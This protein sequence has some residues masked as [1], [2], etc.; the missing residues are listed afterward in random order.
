MMHRNPMFS[1]KK[2]ILIALIFVWSGLALGKLSPLSEAKIEEISNC[3][4]EGTVY[5]SKPVK[6]AGK[7]T[8][9]VTLIA[10]GIK[11]SK[12]IKSESYYC[13]QS[14]SEIDV[15]VPAGPTQGQDA[16]KCFVPETSKEKLV[17]RIDFSNQVAIP[18]DCYRWV[19]DKGL[20]PDKN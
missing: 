12:S 14:K 17:F 10:V 5:S 11:I 6:I 1:F 20:L 4:V 13:K 16:E 2:F 8:T 19:K 7:P 15:I 9:P 18:I 3:I